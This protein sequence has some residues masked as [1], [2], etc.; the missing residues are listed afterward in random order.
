MTLRTR[1]VI[2]ASMQYQYYECVRICV[3]SFVAQQKK[4]PKKSALELVFFAI[5]IIY[6]K[7][8]KNRVYQYFID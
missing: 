4:V 8:L 7:G 5:V 1:V 2:G 6:V 3:L